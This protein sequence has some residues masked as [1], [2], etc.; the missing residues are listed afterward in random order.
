MLLAYTLNGEA[1]EVGFGFPVRLVVPNKYAY[2][3]AL[4]WYIYDLPVAKS[5]AS[6]NGGGIVTMPMYGETTDLI[7]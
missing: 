6:G 3:S 1:F 5:W 2:K 7:S 4:W